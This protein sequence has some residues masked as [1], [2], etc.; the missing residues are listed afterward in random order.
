MT[1][2]Y[3]LNICSSSPIKQTNKTKLETT[4]YTTYA[5]LT[6]EQMPTHYISIIKLYFYSYISIA[7]IR[8][9]T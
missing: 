6:K 7:I 1:K 3:T 4:H 8:E 9:S 2:L 5:P